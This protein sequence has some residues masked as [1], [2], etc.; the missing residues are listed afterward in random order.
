MTNETFKNNEEKEIETVENEKQKDTQE[1]NFQLTEEVDMNALRIIRDNFKIIFEEKLGKSMKMFDKKTGDYIRS[2]DYKQAFTLINELYCSKTKG[3]VVN[4]KFTKNVNYGRR[5]HSTPSLQE[6]VKQVRHTVAKN[7]YLD[8][9][10]KNA[11]PCFLYEYVKECEFYHPML[12]KYIKN[13]EE[14]LTELVKMGKCG[15]R[16][17]AKALILSMINGGGKKNNGVESLDTFYDCQQRFLDTFFNEKKNLKY[18]RRA[19]RRTKD[20][21]KKKEKEG[22]KGFENPKGSALNYYMCEI[23]NIVLGHME[24]FFESRDIRCGTLCFDGLMIYKEDLKEDLKDLLNELEDY[25]EEKMGY[26]L[27][28]AEKEMD[29]GMNLTGLYP[30]EDV[31]TTDEGYAK[32]FLESIKD[33]IKYSR[34]YGTLY[35]FNEY[36]CLWEE[37]PMNSLSILISQ[38]CIPYVENDPDKDKVENEIIRLQ[39]SRHQTSITTIIKQHLTGNSLYNN[40]DFITEHF[41]AGRGSIP[42]SGNRIL[43]LHTLEVRPRVKTDYFTKTTKMNFIDEIPEDKEKAV[44]Q[45]FTDLLSEKTDEGVVIPCSEAYR[46]CLITTI[47][48]F[49][50]G[51]MNESMKKFPN[52]IGSKGDNGKS[53]FLT[54]IGQMFGDF[55][56][57]ASNRVFEKQKNK[58]SHDAE[59]FGL[60]GKWLIT[61]SENDQN[62]FYD[63]EKIKKITGYDTLSLR[64]CGGNSK[65]M[66]DVKFRGVP[67][68]ISN[69][70]CQFEGKA[71]KNRLLCFNFN[72]VFTIDASFGDK[73]KKDI[74][75]YFSVICRYAKE[76]FYDNGKTFSICE[77]VQRYTKEI[78][79][80]KDPFEL[81]RSKQ[82]VYLIGDV[83]NES[84]RIPREKIVNSYMEY[85]EDENIKTLGRNKFYELFEKVCK[86]KAVKKKYNGVQIWLYEGLKEVKG[87]VE[88]V[89]VEEGNIKECPYLPPI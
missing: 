46:D 69:E 10:I 82:D 11:H 49:F 58:S 53:V 68:L 27:G 79:V 9:D 41:D 60:V 6:C 61:L 28:I 70:V 52:F 4:Y 73:L 33:D 39:T 72:N 55:M 37:F 5:F 20:K 48:C 24:T 13:R 59:M 83:N 36:N 63:E 3:N 29:E 19:E 47:G 50:T 18:K 77:E 21:L 56:G 88:E 66:V 15:T 40:D 85:C 76:K 54:F 16:D 25:V 31:N 12:E 87:V 2:T 86:L 65:S 26:R 75:Y 57:N 71:F 62:E 67:L 1:F 35:K 51:E 30:I 22:K 32:Y 45:Y 43:D 74:D 44:L 14:I 38:I 7:I 64:D 84:H 81:W 89:V 80:S 17:D 78:I 23:E 34:R 8:I 42:I